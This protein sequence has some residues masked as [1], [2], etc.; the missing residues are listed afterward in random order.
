MAAAA[1]SAAAAGRRSRRRRRRGSW[2]IWTPEFRLN[3]IRSVERVQILASFGPNNMKRL[4]NEGYN[5]ILI[6]QF[7]V[8]WCSQLATHLFRLTNQA[9]NLTFNTKDWFI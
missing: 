4:Y 1:A 7:D 3:V 6:I 5:L 2:Q 9:P 8:I